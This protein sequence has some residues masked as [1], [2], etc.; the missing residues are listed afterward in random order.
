MPQTWL[1]VQCFQ[2][3]LQPAPPATALAAADA[4]AAAACH[5]SPRASPSIPTAGRGFQVDQEKK[6]NK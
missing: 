5:S 4:L 3:K 2:C 1:V 6:A